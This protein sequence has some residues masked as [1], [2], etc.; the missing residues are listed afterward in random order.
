MTG[1]F[2]LLVILTGAGIFAALLAGI[3]DLATWFARRGTS[4]LNDCPTCAEQ[5]DV[6]RR[7]GVDAR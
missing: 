6:P 1:L 3:A 7:D 5:F 4:R 2:G